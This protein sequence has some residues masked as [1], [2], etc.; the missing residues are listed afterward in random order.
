M[1]NLHKKVADPTAGPRHPVRQDGADVVPVA[2][3]H[4][5]DGKAGQGAGDGRA[6]VGPGPGGAVAVTIF[7]IVKNY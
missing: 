3:P 7:N 2:G 1:L 6:Q 4:R 5:G